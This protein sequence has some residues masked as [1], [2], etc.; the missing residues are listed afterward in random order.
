M[1]N[2]FALASAASAMMISAS[3][4]IARRVG[5]MMAGE[6][7]DDDAIEMVTEKISAFSA[8]IAAATN[9]AIATG[10][11]VLATRALGR[12]LLVCVLL[13]GELRRRAAGGGQELCREPELPGQTPQGCRRQKDRRQKDRR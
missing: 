3:E 9:T 1:N 2:S 8:G 5:L 13:C 12:A 4:V 7:S 10:D 11:L 6:M